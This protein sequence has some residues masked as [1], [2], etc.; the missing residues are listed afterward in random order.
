MADLVGCA[1][2]W[3][4]GG[5]RTCVRDAGEP[6][7]VVGVLHEPESSAALHQVTDDTWT[8]GVDDGLL[9]IRDGDAGGEWR[10]ETTPT[11]GALLEASE[12]RRAGHHAAAEQ[13]LRAALAEGPD[14]QRSARL[15]AALARVVLAGRD[16]ERALTLLARSAAFATEVGFVSQALRDELAIAD[17]LRRAGR[18]DE[19]AEACAVAAHPADPEGAAHLGYQRVLVARDSG[20]LRRALSELDATTA[21]VE[22]YARHPRLRLIALDLAMVRARLLEGLGRS[23][24]AAAVLADV[25]ALAQAPCDRAAWQ[26]NRG[27]V[28]LLSMESADALDATRRLGE[29]REAFG[30]AA[31]LHEHGGACA[32]PSRARNAAV[33]LALTELA[34]GDLTAAEARLEEAAAIDAPR[35][36]RLDAWAALAAARRLAAT[37]DEGAAARFLEVAE[38][39][40]ARTLTGVAWQAWSGLGRLELDRGRLTEAIDAFT[41]AE[42]VL[43]PEIDAVPLGEGRGALADRRS[44]S[45]RALVHA[46]LSRG[47]TAGALRALRRARSRPLRVLRNRTRWL[48]GAPGDGPRWA[49]YREAREAERAHRQSEWSVLPADAP[50]F[51]AEAE[52]LSRRT[53]RTLDAL[54]AVAPPLSS[55]PPPIASDELLLAWAE[56]DSGWR[57]FAATAEH[58]AVADLSEAP[59]PG[60]ELSPMFAPMGEPIARAIANGHTLRL[61]LPPSLEALP[62]HAFPFEGQPLIA[63]APVVVAVDTGS[64]PGRRAV[65]P[66]TLVVADPRGDL[67]AARA[68][69]RAAAGVGDRLLVGEHATRD[70]MLAGLAG[71]THL[72]FAGHASP[73]GALL[74]AGSQLFDTL[75]VLT[76]SAPRTAALLGCGTASSVARA[77]TVGTLGLAQA[78][79]VAGTERVVATIRDVDDRATAAFADALGPGPLTIDSYR[80][81]VLAIRTDHP[82]DWDAFRLLVP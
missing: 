48:R 52:A 59:G 40:E 17:T 15:R 21:H 24:E 74:L 55:E 47:D 34:A 78:F 22:P 76:A 70:A 26:T 68:E 41:R 4:A 25:E 63:A 58:V 12:Q 14:P 81:A 3:V 45:A 50:A 20:D 37:G 67:P 31:D 28:A 32:D 69:G 38:T 11:D 60:T 56:G 73:E 9:T 75:D 43:E 16:I 7:F 29:A 10:I 65:R 62:V 51:E 30:H 8:L 35:E 79:V 82:D 33:N 23:A 5:K 2:I 54:L 44:S 1:E 18:L 39:A 80:S 13:A 36:L 46:L 77:E 42:G 27:W 57:V 61:V 72:H 49:A 66:S 71:A 64:T 6:L 19:A 53:T